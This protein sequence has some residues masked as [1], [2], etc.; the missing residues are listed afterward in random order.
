MLIANDVICRNGISILYTE[1]ADNILNRGC[2]ISMICFA[3]CKLQPSR[4]L[5]SF[6]AACLFG[7]NLLYQNK[8]KSKSNRSHTKCTAMRKVTNVVLQ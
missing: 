8:T 4:R 7:Q 3:T 2:E 6:L 5:C 1:I